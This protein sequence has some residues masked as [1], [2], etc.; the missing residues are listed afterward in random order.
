[1]V[2]NIPIPDRGMG[3]HKILYLHHYLA[4]LPRRLHIHIFDLSPDHRLNQAFSES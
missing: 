3:H 2:H 1:M 4:G